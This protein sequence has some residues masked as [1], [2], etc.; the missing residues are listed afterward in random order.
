MNIPKS[1]IRLTMSLNQPTSLSALHLIPA[2]IVPK[3]LFQLPKSVSIHSAVMM[4]TRMK[5]TAVAMRENRAEKSGRGDHLRLSS[6]PR[7]SRSSLIHL[8]H[9]KKDWHLLRLRPNRRER[10]VPYPI[11]KRTPFHDGSPLHL[12]PTSRNRLFRPRGL[13]R[14]LRTQSLGFFPSL[15]RTY[16]HSPVRPRKRTKT[17]LICICSA[18]LTKTLTANGRGRKAQPRLGH[19]HKNEN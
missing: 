18:Q 3:K 2:S 4:K 14:Q 7:H 11:Q 12:L 15:L 10:Q 13:R 5:S 6:N 19:L 1:L 16:R 9:L 17:C 8:R